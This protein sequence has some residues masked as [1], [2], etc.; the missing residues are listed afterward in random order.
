VCLKLV[1]LWA[2][3]LD[4]VVWKYLNTLETQLLTKDNE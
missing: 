1:I 2:L 3:A 4:C